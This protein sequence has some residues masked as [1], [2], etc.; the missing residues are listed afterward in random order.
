MNKKIG[1]ISLLIGC[2]TFVSYMYVNKEKAPEEKENHYYKTVVFKDRD[3][4]LIPISMD[5]HNQME[6]EQEIMNCIDIMKSTEFQ[7]YGL[8]P[9]LSS[10]LE[11]LSVELKNHVLTLNT[12][13]EIVA[14]S[15]ALNIL[16][17][18]TFTCTDYDDVSRLQLQINGQ[19]I[20]NLPNSFI[21]VSSLTKDLGLNNFIETSTYLHETVP[22]MV[23]KQKNI[24]NYSYYIPTTLR[25]EENDSIDKQVKTIL[26]HIQS[27]IQLIDASLEDG[28]LHVQ[29]GSNILLDNEKIDQALEDLIVLSLSTLKGVDNVD[30]TINKE[31]VRTKESS[32]IEYNRLKI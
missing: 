25:I 30:I 3:N 28:T 6:L 23:Y 5:L 22:V 32:I 29:L 19:N 2:L 24:M 8:Y 26:S 14:N 10:E 21:P 16:E 27:R 31:S 12:N 18:L 15:D 11:V 13:D 4:E 1:V 17:A 7:E 9:V 20:S